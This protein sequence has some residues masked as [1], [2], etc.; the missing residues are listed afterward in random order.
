[1]LSSRNNQLRLKTSG[2]LSI[3]VE[4]YVEYTSNGWKQ[5]RKMSTCNRLWSKKTLNFWMMVFEE[6]PK[7]QRKSQQFD[8][9]M[10]NLMSTWP[11]TLPS[12]Q[13]P[14]VLWR[15]PVGLLTQKRQ[16]KKHVTGWLLESPWSQPTLYAHHKLPSRAP[17]VMNE[18]GSSSGNR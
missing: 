10:W 11:K 6:I 14:L 7:S 18:A 16:E 1:M 17:A 2:N 12:G 4:E 15:W 3:I 8:S 9:H 5:S 13:L